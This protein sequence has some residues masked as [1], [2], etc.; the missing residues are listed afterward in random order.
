MLRKRFTT[1]SLIYL[2]YT[3]IQNDSIC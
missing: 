2:K 3:K 1:Y